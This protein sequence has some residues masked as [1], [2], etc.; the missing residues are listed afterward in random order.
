MQDK[1][2]VTVE[3]WSAWAPGLT[4]KNEWQEW[5]DGRRSIEGPSKPD[6]SFVEPMMR[7][8]LSLQTRMAF[9]VAADCLRDQTRP[10]A[11]IF[12]SR[13]GEYGRTFQMLNALA[14]ELQ[15]SALAFSM[16]VHNTSSS[17]FSIESQDTAT[18]SAIA[19]GAASLQSAFVDAWSLLQTKEATSVLVVFHDEPLPDLYSSFTEAGDHPMALALLLTLPE[20]SNLTSSVTLQWARSD[21]NIEAQPS[22][23]VSAFEFILMLLNKQTSVTFDAGRLVW[24]WNRSIEKN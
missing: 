12:C 15:V 8:K 21:S 6:V 16:S 23:M 1:L 22:S 4:S 2:T 7:R 13:Y 11:H 10:T 18:S 17:L 5:A 3:N 19:A 24:I 20:T 9:C 14:D